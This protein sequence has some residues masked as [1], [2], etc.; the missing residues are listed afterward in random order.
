MVDETL[1]LRK[2]AQLEEYAS[3]IEEYRSV[4]LE[5]YRD[6]WKLQR[7][8]ERT[9]QMMIETCVDIAGHIISDNK[10]RIPDSYAD[11]FR[12]LSENKI[13]T[14]DLCQTMEQISK[15]RNVIVH[16]YDRV[17]AEIVVEILG[18]RINDFN[19][20]KDAIVNWLKKECV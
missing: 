7:I 13:I 14:A 12:V 11:S 20:Y 19:R 8:I 15:F 5:Q 17:D 16:H 9:L 6:D 18:K 4:T 2:L 10:F 1:M 3:Q